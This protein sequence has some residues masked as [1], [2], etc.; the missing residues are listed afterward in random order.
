VPRGTQDT[1]KNVTVVATGLSPSLV[2]LPR[3]FAFRSAPS[4]SP[5]TPLY[6]YNGLG[7]SAFARHYSRNPLFS[8]GY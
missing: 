3:P 2:G 6:M 1:P 8:S 5:T 4:R 7:F